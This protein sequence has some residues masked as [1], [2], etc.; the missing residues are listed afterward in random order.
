MIGK[1]TF[2]QNDKVV[3]ECSNIITTAGKKAIIE[4][5]A[6]YSKRLVGSITVGVGST[7]AAASD[8]RMNFE[9]TRGNVSNTGIDYATNSVIFRAQ[10]LP[11]DSFI[12]YEMGAH[13]LT[14]DVGAYGSSLI[15][16]FNEVT[17][18]WSIGTWT[19]TNSRMGS[20]LQVT[21]PA[22]TST[23]SIL[24][25]I[26]M[27]LSGYSNN[28][29]FILAARANNAFVASITI[30]IRTDASNFYSWTINAPA[31]GVYAISSTTKSS[32][33]AT[34]APSW[35]NITQAV[36]RVTSTAG[37][38]G[39]V[40]FDGIRVEDVD[41]NKEESVL[42]SRAVLGSPVTKVAGVPLEI[43]YSVTI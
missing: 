15:I 28:D 12:I 17:D 16:D 31:S 1:Y 33:T 22:S 26:A 11:N 2:R 7:A 30:Q 37:G 27:D 4:F 39:S 10:L 13:T 38:V 8:R 35:A 23:D 6:G 40:D 42:I 34:G 3:A 25:D 9:A 41:A 20:A 43:E 18:P 5:F 21:A 24:S 19:A 32:M 14:S 36:V 29:I